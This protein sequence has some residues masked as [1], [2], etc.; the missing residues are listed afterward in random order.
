[1]QRV[2]RLPSCIPVTA[3]VVY[4]HR[5][6]RG[7]GDWLGTGNVANQLKKYR[8]FREARVFVRRLKLKSGNEWRAFCKGEIPPLGRLPPDI[9]SAADRIYA[10]KGWV[11][12]GDW[13]G[14]GSIASNQRKF[15]PFLGAR[16]FVCQLQLKS[17]AQW[18]AYCKG[19]LPEKP[20]LP[21]D[22]PAH[23]DRTYA[24]R[25]WLGWGYWL[26]TGTIASRQMKF[27]SFAEARAF[28]HLLQLKSEADWRLFC[29][30]QLPQKGN[31]PTDLPA[32]PERVYAGQGWAGWRDWLRTGRMRP[33][34]L[35]GPLRR[36]RWTAST[37][38]AGL[39][40]DAFPRGDRQRPLQP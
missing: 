23:P 7:F 22:I 30:G 28:V 18:R 33:R 25:G 15:R 6:W 24:R 9:P 14:T 29:T 16:A 38:M 12:W 26:G 5:G 40:A 37:R 34:L 32:H 11:S 4:A 35:G 3:S 36:L 2:G 31:R 39:G 10:G 8:S 20:R 21:E 19:K 17:E 13:L 1:M 27:R